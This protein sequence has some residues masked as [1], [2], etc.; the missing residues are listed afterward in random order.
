WPR[1]RARSSRGCSGAWRTSAKWS[2]SITVGSSTGSRHEH[3]GNRGGVPLNILSRSSMND[4][5]RQGG[6][7]NEHTELQTDLPAYAARRLEPEARPRI[8]A[9]LGVCEECRALVSDFEALGRAIEKAGAPLLAAHPPVAALRHHARRRGGPVDAD[10]QRHLDLCPSR[11]LEAQ[12]GQPAPLAPPAAVRAAGWAAVASAA[13]GLLVGTALASLLTGAPPRPAALFSP[14]R[15]IDAPQLIL[16]PHL[17]SE[18]G[19]IAYAIDPAQ[20]AV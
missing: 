4:Q 8:E 3:P 17:R 1:R 15:A 18:P 16:P 20:E 6:P 10:M 5:S 19:R 2:V 9:H 12:A 13:A 7:M 11:G 14:P